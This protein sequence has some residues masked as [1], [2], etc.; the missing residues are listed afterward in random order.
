LL[1]T[2]ATKCV[3]LLSTTPSRSASFSQPTLPQSTTTFCWHPTSTLLLT[4]ARFR[5]G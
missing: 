2:A 3:L 4:L 1:P 5:L